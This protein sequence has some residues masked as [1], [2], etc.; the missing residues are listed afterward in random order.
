MPINPKDKAR[1]GTKE[2]RRTHQTLKTPGPLLVARAA[3]RAVTLA[4]RALVAA[5]TACQRAADKRRS[6]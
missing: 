1:G 4:R 3:A 6:T 2:A 5:S